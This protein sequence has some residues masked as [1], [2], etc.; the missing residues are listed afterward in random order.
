[1]L[2][3]DRKAELLEDLPASQTIYFFKGSKDKTER[4]GVVGGGCTP[5]SE[6]L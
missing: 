1:M 3:D 6:E 2:L 5:E 4:L